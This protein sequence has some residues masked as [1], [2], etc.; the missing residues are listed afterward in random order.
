MVDPGVKISWNKLER[1]S[2]ARKFK[3]ETFRLQNYWILQPE[4]HERYRAK[5]VS[6]LRYINTIVNR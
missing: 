3:P 4:L 1:Y 6:T 2:E 5:N